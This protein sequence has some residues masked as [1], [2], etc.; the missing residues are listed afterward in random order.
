MPSA[1]PIDTKKYSKRRLGGNIVAGLHVVG[2]PTF[3]A[4]HNDRG[5]HLIHWRV[6]LRWWDE[7]RQG[8]DPESVA[9]D[10]RKESDTDAIVATVIASK[11][12][13]AS[14]HAEDYF[15]HDV[16]LRRRDLTVQNFVDLIHYS[17]RDRYSY[18]GNGSGCLFWSNALLNDYAGAGWVYPSATAAFADYIASIRWGAT[19]KYWIPEDQGT[20]F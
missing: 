14:R 9:L 1:K 17:R 6:H 15:V 4:V 8:L 13:L 7:S 16:Q 3:P 19:G 18:D 10:T 12:T 5:E 11:P 2:V 20:F